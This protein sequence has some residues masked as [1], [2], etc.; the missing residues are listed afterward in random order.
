MSLQVPTSRYLPLQFIA[1]IIGELSGRKHF[2]KI[3]LGE[4][5]NG[6]PVMGLKFGHG[7][8]KVLAWS[9]MHGNE[10]TT[11]KALLEYFLKIIDSE[12]SRTLAEKLTIFTIPILNPDGAAV[13]TR[14]NAVEID[15]NRDAV[16]LSQPESNILRAAYESFK[17]DLCLN[18]HGQRSIYGL[19]GT[20]NPAIVSFL[21]PAADADRTVTD[22]R[23]VAMHYINLMS[24]ELSAEIGNCIG[25]YDDSYNAN[26][27]GDSFTAEGTPTILFEAGQYGLDYQR[28]NTKALLVKALE[29]L[30]N[31]FGTAELPDSQGILSDYL[32]LPENAI[33]Y[34]DIIFK[35]ALPGKD[36]Q[37]G[38][39]AA[40]YKEHLQDNNIQF[41]P[42]VDQMGKLT[43]PYAHRVVN[44]AELKALLT[45]L[46]EADWPD[47]IEKY[48]HK[49]F[50]L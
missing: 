12:E 36:S 13:F 9:Q 44:G 49:N 3:H 8:F 50:R 29:T 27:V 39:I 16:D 40:Q 46:D 47:F 30:F 21:A 5:V 34:F 20:E 32:S 1:P 43:R 25:R 37:N 45:D 23:L 15:L 28:N 7:A 35:A 33:S 22:A 10:S 17:P 24:A 2:T 48:V 19:T 42:E 26:C 41:I 11:T 4:S 6:E 18:M 38:H 14:E 31:A